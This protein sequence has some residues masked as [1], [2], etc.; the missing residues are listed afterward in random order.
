V[1]DCVVPEAVSPGFRKR[2]GPFLLNPKARMTMLDT[3]IGSPNKA[4]SGYPIVADAAIG[5]RAADRA[6]PRVAAEGQPSRLRIA[7]D[8]IKRSL[9]RRP[10]ARRCDQ[11]IRSSLREDDWA[12]TLE[13]LPQLAMVVLEELTRFYNIV[14]HA[15]V[16]VAVSQ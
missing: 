9:E 11:T 3:L 13:P 14:R 2:D 8:P 4:R 12:D 6:R 5:L 16:R 15:G 7:N 1:Y 10:I